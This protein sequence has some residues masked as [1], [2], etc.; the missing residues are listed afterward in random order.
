MF[1]IR[2][3]NVFWPQPAGKGNGFILRRLTGHY[4]SFCR[5]IAR[6]GIARGAQRRLPGGAIPATVLP[7]LKRQSSACLLLRCAT[8]R[9]EAPPSLRQ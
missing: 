9:Q 6:G 1:L 8:G 4:S 7:L 5:I 3:G 2:L